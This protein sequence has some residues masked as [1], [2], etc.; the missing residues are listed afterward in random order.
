M[1]KWFQRRELERCRKTELRGEK[2]G[3]VSGSK[4]YLL[5]QR[6]CC[7]SWKDHKGNSTEDVGRIAKG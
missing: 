6:F 7:S 5:L 4:E 2:L 3:E 1:L